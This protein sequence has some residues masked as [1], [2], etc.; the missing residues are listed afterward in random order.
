MFT[1]A[2][3]AAAVFHTPHAVR[4]NTKQTAANLP[5][6]GSRLKNE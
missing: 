6:F 1:P 4:A 2:A 3:C 5:R